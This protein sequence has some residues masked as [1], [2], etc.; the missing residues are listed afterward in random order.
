MKLL[1]TLNLFA[2]L[3]HLFYQLGLLTRQYIFPSIVY[4][5]CWAEWYI[6][7]ALKIP[8]YYVK[9]REQRLLLTPKLPH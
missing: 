6:L 3:I 9:V 8:Y 5:Y 1:Q 7:P 4:V 2:E